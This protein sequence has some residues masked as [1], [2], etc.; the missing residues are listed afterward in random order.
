M[1]KIIKKNLNNAPDETRAFEKGKVEIASLNDVTIG[2]AELEPGW[3]WEKCVKPIA[4]T[5]SCEAPHTQYVISG[6][7]KVVMDDGTE[8]EFGPGDV[9]IVPPGHNAWVV[10]DEK[11]IAIDFTGMTKYAKNQ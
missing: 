11:C 5:N 3:S 10:G 2:R 4:K 7:M 9:G 1:A 8:E 6:R